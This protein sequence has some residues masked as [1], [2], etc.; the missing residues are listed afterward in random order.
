MTTFPRPDLVA[1][2]RY[3]IERRAD[4]YPPL[5][6][7]GRLDPDAATLDFQAWHGIAEWLETGHC[8]LIGQAGGVN[9]EEPTTIDWALLAGAADKGLATIRKLYRDEAAYARNPDDPQ[10]AALAAAEL[11]QLEQ[12]GRDLARIQAAVAAHKRIRDDLNAELR[13]A[14]DQQRKAA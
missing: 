2:A 10:R 1:A 6:V 13:N 8:R 7:Q 9:T 14:A 5:V 12:R 3:E 11:A 4:A